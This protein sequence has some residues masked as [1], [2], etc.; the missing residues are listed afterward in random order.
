MQNI[1]DECL[2]LHLP[3]FLCKWLIDQPVNLIFQ[4]FASFPVCHKGVSVHV[5]GAYYTLTFIRCIRSDLFDQFLVPP[6]QSVKLAQGNC[7]LLLSAVG[8]D[9]CNVF[10][11][12]PR[13]SLF[14][15]FVPDPGTSFQDGTFLFPCHNDKH[16]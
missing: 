11:S 7:R 15:G 12:N 2:R 9:P 14:T 13:F 6:V 5:K 4:M 10:H 3:Q 8:F 16:R 1:P